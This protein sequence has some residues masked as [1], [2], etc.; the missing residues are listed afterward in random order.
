MPG[1][2]GTRRAERAWEAGSAGKLRLGTNGD[3]QHEQVGY[4]G[5]EEGEERGRKK[6]RKQRRNERRGTV[7]GGRTMKIKE[8]KEE[9][10]MEGGEGRE[11]K[12]G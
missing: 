6:R 10:A 4:L 8:E 9:V 1:R 2:S 11:A 12:E 3:I 5:E 7:G